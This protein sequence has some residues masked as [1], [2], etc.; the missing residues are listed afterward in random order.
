MHKRLII[1]MICISP[2]VLMTDIDTMLEIEEKIPVVTCISNIYEEKEEFTNFTCLL[3]CD[4]LSAYSEEQLKRNIRK[5]NVIIIHE[6]EDLLRRA[7]S[8]GYETMYI[9]KKKNIADYCF[10]SLEDM[11]YNAQRKRKIEKVMGGIFMFLAV[12]LLY[13]PLEM[14][15]FENQIVIYLILSI[16]SL[17]TSIY[18]FRLRKIGDIILYV[19]DAIFKMY[20]MQKGKLVFTISSPL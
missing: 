20:N 6:D 11:I 10:E 9:G 14:K 8:F 19:F 4:E 2:K 16:M 15:L 13:L 18:F 7:K 3:N 17:I 5:K 1:D 12:I